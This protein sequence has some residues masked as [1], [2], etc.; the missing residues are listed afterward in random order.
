MKVI[1]ST[2]GAPA[3]GILFFT[4]IETEIDGGGLLVV[5][6]VPERSGLYVCGDVCRGS[7]PYKKREYIENTTKGDIELIISQNKRAMI[8]KITETAANYNK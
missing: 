3:V 5:E 1:A 7:V 2:F 6:A 4:K 8:D